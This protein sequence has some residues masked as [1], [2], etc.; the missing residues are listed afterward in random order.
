MPRHSGIHR[1]TLYPLLPLAWLCVVLLLPGLARGQG[2]RQRPAAFPDVVGRSLHEVLQ[3]LE[4]RGLPLVYTDQLVS[5]TLRVHRQPQGN[6]LPDLLLDLLKDHRLSAQQAGRRWIVV[7]APPR[8]GI[9]SGL[10]HSQEPGV[11]PTGPSATTPLPGVGVSLLPTNAMSAG[12]TSVS[13]TSVSDTGGRFRFADLPPGTYTLRFEL[14]GF[15]PREHTFQLSSGQVLDLRIA[16]QKIPTS[17]EQ[18]EVTTEPP[19]ILGSALSA[20]TLTRSELD[21]LPHFGDHTLRGLVLLPG[22]AGNDLSAEL[23][24][25]GGRADEVLVQLDGL[26]IFEAY[27]LPDFGNPFS[28]FASETLHRIDLLTG[29]FPVEYG[30]RMAGVLDIT[31]IDPDWRR[32][33]HL[34]F[35]GYQLRTGQSGTSRSGRL[36]YVGS[37]RLGSLELPLRLAD[38]DENPSFADGFFKV[39]HFANPRT[40]W[41]FN[42]LS[43]SNRLDFSVIEDDAQESFET[44][45][46]NLYGW[47]THGHTVGDDLYLRTQISWS[48]IARRRLGLQSGD[49]DTFDL[50]DLRQLTT[51]GLRHEA[52]WRRGRHFLEWG[53]EGRYLEVDYDYTHQRELQDPLALIRSQPRTGSTRF[54]RRFDG[55]QYA[56]YLSDQIDLGHRATLEAGLRF[57]DN[58]LTEDAR[59]S[60]RL[61]FTYALSPRSLLRGAWGQYN[62]SQRVYEL[63]VEDGDTSFS[64]AERSRHHIVGFEQVFGDAETLR[65]VT[66]RVEAYERRISTP[67]SRYENLFEPITIV[68]ELEADRIRVDAEESRARGIELVLGGP[69]SPRLEGFLTYTYS[70][71]RDLVEGRWVPRP[72]DQPHAVSLDISWRAPWHWHVQAVWRY[73]TGWPT[74]EIGLINQGDNDAVPVLG[75]LYGSRVRDYDRLDVRAQRS[76]PLR[77]GDLTFFIG[78]QNLTNRSNVRGFDFDLE[79]EDDVILIESKVQTW[80]GRLPSLGLTWTF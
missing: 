4:E 29:G 19:G 53:V 66:L 57:D 2:E 17:V 47:G 73:H 45:Y 6:D 75:P 62:Q 16:L 20:L 12:D 58:T 69:L 14:D 32:R 80:G 78:V 54:D 60:P 27:H 70:R 77:R 7:A 10:L 28:V 33:S 34:G 9:L 23:N 1:K 56:V 76:W 68:P 13:D 79:D 63:A 36:A 49:D 42:G 15:L 64:P 37:L 5:P 72:Y 40:S 41:R 21:S 31:T 30:D 51:A 25:R 43:S 50:S 22:T 11:E 67:R 3:L 18:I 71:S 61:H 52:D 39:E 65:P 48:R 46:D 55:Q 38:E 74:T 26:E 24:V 8:P 35:S 44:K 59:L